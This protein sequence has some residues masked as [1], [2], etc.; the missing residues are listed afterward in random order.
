[1]PTQFDGSDFVKNYMKELEKQFNQS[2]SFIE[3]AL[4]TKKAAPDW[5]NAAKDLANNIVN[6]PS[7]YGIYTI[8]EEIHKIARMIDPSI[9]EPKVTVA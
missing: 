6:R 4:K 7:N 2:N 5:R 9:P 3:D 8:Y 1:M